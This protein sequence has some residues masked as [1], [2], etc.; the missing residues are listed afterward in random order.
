MWL[1][2]WIVKGTFILHPIVSPNNRLCIKDVHLLHQIIKL[3]W[4][5]QVYL[6][7]Q[8]SAEYKIISVQHFAQ[9]SK[10]TKYEGD[11]ILFLKNGPSSNSFSFIFSLFKQTI[12]ILQQIDLHP[13]YITRILTRDLLFMSLLL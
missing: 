13:V 4:E 11:V 6:Q 12:Q 10:C 9:K 8:F 3:I 7:M 1:L 5:Y 2:M